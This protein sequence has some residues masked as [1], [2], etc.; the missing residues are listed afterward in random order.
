VS[1]DFPVLQQV[2]SR[3]YAARAIRFCSDAVRAAWAHSKASRQVVKGHAALGSL[4]A[5]ARLRFW[6]ITIVWMGIGLML[7][8][9]LV[10]RYS[11]PVWPVLQGL[12]VALLG[13]V[14]A[15]SSTPLAA[16]WPRSG[17]RRWLQAGRAD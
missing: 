4:P 1:A 16:A 5:G 6:S 3:S 13:A 14:L 10:P 9:V 12:S 2:L 7:S 8:G 15:A 17:L 11:A